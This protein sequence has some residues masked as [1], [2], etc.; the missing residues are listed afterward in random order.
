MESTLS[1]L[2]PLAHGALRIVSGFLFA[3]HGAQKIIPGAFGNLDGSTAKLWSLVWFAGIIEL[4]GGSLI[5]IGVRTQIAAF[6]CSGE[7][8]V[9]YFRAH[10]PGGLLPI[11]NKGDLA[12][13]FCFVFFYLATN[14]GG[15]FGLERK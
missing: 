13:L 9:A 14:G 5:A 2:G 12:V 10:Q 1:K 4:V 8:A 3:C 15:P 7:M 11:H 6:I